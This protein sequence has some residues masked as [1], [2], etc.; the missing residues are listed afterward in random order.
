M[1]DSDFLSRLVVSAGVLGLL[2]SRC[3]R[4][5]GDEFLHVRLDGP[6]IGLAHANFI[7]YLGCVDDDFADPNLIRD[8]ALRYDDHADFVDA[9]RRIC[10][11]TCR[12][13]NH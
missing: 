5:A 11:E 7:G 2:G 4:H 13:P 8:E 12:V 9:K 1:V 3:W 10:L 6:D